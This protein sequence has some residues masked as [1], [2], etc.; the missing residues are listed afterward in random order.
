MEKKNEKAKSTCV[1]VSEQRHLHSLAVIL[2]TLYKTSGQQSE[3][4][5]NVCLDIQVLYLVSR[6]MQ[7][8]TD[9]LQP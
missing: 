7:G 2:L 1:I 4:T 6:N 5:I 8:C 3:H 9:A